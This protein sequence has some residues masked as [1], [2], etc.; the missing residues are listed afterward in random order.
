M[1]NNLF[2]FSSI[3]GTFHAT[4]YKGIYV[5]QLHGQMYHHVP[6]LLPHDG[7]PKYLQLYFYDG[8]HEA[9]NRSGC[10]PEAQNKVM[11]PRIKSYHADNITATSYK[12]A[13][14][15]CY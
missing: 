9:L 1:Y 3:G 6:T 13:P 8:H 2:A 4:T 14:E 12:T 5:F 7:R 15:I 11:V 10:F